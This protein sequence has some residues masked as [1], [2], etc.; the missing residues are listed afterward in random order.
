MMKL[1]VN[2]LTKNLCFQPKM[3]FLDDVPSSH[4]PPRRSIWTFCSFLFS[5]GILPLSLPSLPPVGSLST[6]LC[7]CLEKTLPAP[8]RQDLLC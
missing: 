4:P 3:S 1:K 5:Q 8:L 2:T 6:Y 7:A